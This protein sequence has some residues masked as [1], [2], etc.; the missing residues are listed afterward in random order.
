MPVTPFAPEQVGRPV[1]LSPAD[2][3][4]G[5]NLIVTVPASPDGGTLYKLDSIRFRVV[6]S[7]TAANRDVGVEIRDSGGSTIV[8]SA[9][10]PSGTP[11]TATQTRDYNW[12][13]GLPVHEIFIPNL[14]S[15]WL[16]DAW[17]LPGESIRT[18]ITNIQAGDQISAVIIAVREWRV[19][20]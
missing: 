8:V 19:Q 5:N 7:G 3:S 12:V 17:A 13:R 15:L 1:R 9:Y 2:P 18:A 6:T 4:A 14:R 20:A 16:F 11:Q 10:P